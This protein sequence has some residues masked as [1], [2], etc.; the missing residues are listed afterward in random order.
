MSKKY[1]SVDSENNK[2]QDCIK[3]ENEENEVTAG[4]IRTKDSSDTFKD[5]K[6]IFI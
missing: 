5:I 6:E 1:I 3:M 2:T 4:Q